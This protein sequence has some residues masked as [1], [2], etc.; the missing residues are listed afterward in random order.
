M[1]NALVRLRC[2]VPDS[3]GWNRTPWR[4]IQSRQVD[5]SRITRRASVF[6]G[7]AAGDLEQVLPELFF[8]VGLGQHVLRRVVHAA[9]VARVHRVAAAP[10]AG[11]CLQQ[12]DAAARLARDQCR[13]QG[14]IAATNDQYIHQNGLQPSPNL[15]CTLST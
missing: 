9:Q 11:S 14:C 10:G 6:V 3:D 1:K 5:D 8:R 7:L 4:R 13:T 12:H 15:R 2:S